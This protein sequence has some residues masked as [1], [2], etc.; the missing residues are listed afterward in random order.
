MKTESLW[1]IFLKKAKEKVT[2]VMFDTWFEEN[3]LISIE[4]NLFI[5]EVPSEI[6]QKHLKQKYYDLIKDIVYEITE[7]NFEIEFRLENESFEE[8]KG[9]VPDFQPKDANLNSDY[10]FEEFIV[11]NSNKFAH[12]AALAVAENP[13]KIYN[14]LF[15]Y[16]N[17]GLGKTHLMHAIGNFILE[18]TNKSVLYITSEQF[19]EDFIGMTGKKKDNL[20]YIKYFKDKYRNID[21]LMVDDIQ[22]LAGA[23]TTQQEFFQTFNKLYNDKKQIIISS[24]RSPDDLKLLEE[25]LRTRFNWGLT[26]NIYP[27]DFTLRKDILIKKI[28]NSMLN[29]EIPEEVVDYIA[30][31][32]ESDVRKLEGA[33]TRLFAFS[34]MMGHEKMDLDIAIEALKDY[35]S[36]PQQITNKLRKIQ[37]IIADYY[38]ISIDDF[39]S[40]KRTQKIAE[41]RQIAM[42]LCRKHT[43]ESFPKIGSEFGGRD[44]TTVMHAC[45]KMDKLRNERQEFDKL[46]IKFEKEINGGD[47]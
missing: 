36:K 1:Q 35:I 42:Y 19:I 37:M 27:P 23:T 17:S 11:G 33:I 22:F 7:T 31:N 16:G 29:E 26:V 10:S 14:P 6:H 8:A 32:C 45:E 44:H 15:L 25:R 24:D 39:K 21:V 47:K 40:K 41:P 28:Q 2:P 34:A 18:N 43:S 9:G 30:T 5:I 38:K 46:L 4:D 12:A 13:G 3:K 20:D